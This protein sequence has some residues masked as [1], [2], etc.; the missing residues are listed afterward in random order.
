MGRRLLRVYFSTKKEIMMKTEIEEDALEWDRV[1]E[2]ELDAIQAIVQGL[3]RN[4][5]K[6]FHYEP[7]EPQNGFVLSI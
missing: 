5:M 6:I 4:S 2:A 1:I 3:V 7:M